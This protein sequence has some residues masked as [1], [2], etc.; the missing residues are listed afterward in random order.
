MPLH[1]LVHVLVAEW[2]ENLKLYMY[3]KFND[4]CDPLV[5]PIATECTL[6]QRVYLTDFHIL[7]NCWNGQNL[8][9][10]PTPTLRLHVDFIKYTLVTQGYLEVR[11]YRSLGRLASFRMFH[12]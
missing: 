4:T 9:Y 12:V 2:F 5:V 10:G 7:E 1:V 11:K 3:L 6:R 8:R